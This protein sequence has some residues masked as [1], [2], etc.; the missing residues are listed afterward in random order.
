MAAI[1]RLG[2]DPADV[3]RAFGA[4]QGD[5]RKINAQLNRDAR[6]AAADRMR[7]LR[8][9]QTE[10]QRSAAAS[11]RARQKA[12]QD[13]T[14][15]VANEAKKRERAEAAALA[16]AKR[17]RDQYYKS[18]EQS[19]QRATRVTEREALARTRAHQR[20]VREVQAAAGRLIAGAASLGAASAGTVHAMVQGARERR[21]ST[22]RTLNQ[23]L[24][25]AGA[26]AQGAAADRAQIHAFALANRMDSAALAGGLNVMQTEFSSLG[27]S[28][29]SDR[30]RTRNIDRALQ[31]ALLARDTGQDVGEVM[32]VSGLL[33]NAGIRGGANRA[34]LLGLTGMAQRGAI[35]LRSVS[36]EAMAPMM[37]RM[38]QAQQGLLQR[39][40]HA[41]EAEQAEV[42]RAAA[43][44]SF[45][46]IEVARSQGATP[47]RFARVM[48]QLGTEL[49]GSNRQHMLLGNINRSHD[50]NDAER[51]ELR[52]MFDDH[53]Q[54]RE[55]FQSG[56]GFAAAVH[57]ITGGN[58][59]KM[60]NVFS[61]GGHG[62]PM[63]LQTNWR[64]A[65]AMMGSGNE[66]VNR[67]I[68]GVGRDF[69]EEDVR[70]GAAL[71]GND[72]QSQLTKNQEERE[73]ALVGNTSA[74]TELSNRFA[75]WT[76]SNPLTAGL[77]PGIA[78]A[79]LPSLGKAA[80]GG[81]LPAIARMGGIAAG[82][83]GAGA[84]T[85]AGLAGGI[86]GIGTGVGLTKVMDSGTRHGVPG[87]A[88]TE[89]NEIT[90][91]NII[92]NAIR[93]GISSATV[94]ATVAPHDAAHAATVA[95]ATPPRGVGQ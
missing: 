2:A 50:L 24:Y 32:R 84:A 22:D 45:A 37:S 23:A 59:A 70:R 12:E 26:G 55:Q 78:A 86:V 8:Q 28:R 18:L 9:E 95:G 16:G 15:A 66:E 4:L 61:G 54:L 47:R 49:Q 58:E 52:R 39:N 67:M 19:E 63:G 75:A 82:A 62:N 41:T 29:T 87:L 57:Q 90:L 51:S 69:T 10:H 80:G 79:V 81:V 3:R 53:G 77:A 36:R 38:H 14:R 20:T 74:I 91:F 64:D 43:M 68:R 76:A 72:D 85:V 6:A 44:Q 83:V 27:N 56:L 73:Q 31:T 93:D 88:T 1:L 25:Q 42:Q 13:A 60:R 11:V 35:E 71:F 46:E 89:G 7:A 65:I 5:A 17:T 94:T 40:P 48:A 92:R 34:A 21:A 30:D 33:E